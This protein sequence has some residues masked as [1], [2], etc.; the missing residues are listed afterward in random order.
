MDIQTRKILFVKKFLDISNEKI[1]SKLEKI[2][3]NEIEFKPE[4]NPK[5]SE[6]MK[7]RISQ[8]L[9]DADTGRLIEQSN[10]ELEIEKWD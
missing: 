3:K 9:N 1:I 10:L 6:E 2:L 7:R 4:L 8:S 5:T